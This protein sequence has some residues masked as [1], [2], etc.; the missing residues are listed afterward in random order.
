MLTMLTVSPLQTHLL[1]P[2]I[3]N[4]NDNHRN[5]NDDDEL[6]VEKETTNI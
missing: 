6:E 4:N 2:H 3:D 5:N 1:F